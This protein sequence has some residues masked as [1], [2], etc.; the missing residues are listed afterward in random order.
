ME[1]NQLLLM[2]VYL[3]HEPSRDFF[4]SKALT[5]SVCA[6]TM[7]PMKKLAAR[8]AKKEADFEVHP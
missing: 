1:E 8:W 3:N 6:A 4:K 7:A 2:Y 5:L